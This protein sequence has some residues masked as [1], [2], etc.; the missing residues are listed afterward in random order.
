MLFDAANAYG[1]RFVSLTTVPLFDLSSVSQMLIM[2]LI[3]KTYA[4]TVTS[5]PFQFI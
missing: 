1:I 3:F 2:F 4:L 5:I